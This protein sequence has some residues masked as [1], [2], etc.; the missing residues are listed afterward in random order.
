MPAFI[1]PMLCERLTN[2]PKWRIMVEIAEPKLDV[3]SIAPLAGDL[4][5]LE[6]GHRA[7]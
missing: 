4:S 1:P 5:R 6:V 3:G 2:L 7:H